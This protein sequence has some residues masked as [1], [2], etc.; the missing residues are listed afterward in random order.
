[1]AARSTAEKIPMVQK[2]SSH[3]SQY[4]NKCQI[5]AGKSPEK[6]FCSQRAV[7]TSL[8]DLLVS[9]PDNVQVKYR[10]KVVNYSWPRPHQAAE[11]L[12]WVQVTLASG[13]TVQT[14]LLVRF[15]SSH[16]ADV[17]GSVC[18]LFST[19]ML[20]FSSVVRSAQMDQT[21]WS[22]KSWG[23]PQS[24]GTTTSRLWWQCC[25]CPR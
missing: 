8:F 2:H 23:S 18:F 22:G 11:S 16:A 25:T 21:Q 9:R 5:K 12:P 24:S 17:H 20:F 1:M 6:S 15:G 19:L 7:T 3:R 13:E 14:K 4:K 10:S